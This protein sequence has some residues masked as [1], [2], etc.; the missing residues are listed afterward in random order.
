M[1]CVSYQLYVCIIRIV[2]ALSYMHIVHIIRIIVDIVCI[3]HIMHNVCIIPY[4]VFH[5]HITRIT[6]LIVHIVRIIHITCITLLLQD[7]LLRAAAGHCS[8][9]TAGCPARI[10]RTIP[11]GGDLLP[12]PPD[13]IYTFMF[14]F[15][16]F[17]GGTSMTGGIIDCR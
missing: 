2:C 9:Q 14:C 3:T 8:L 6:R 5:I 15:L 12:P 17:S 11:W 4:H 13:H 16:S 10:L 7:V 1:M